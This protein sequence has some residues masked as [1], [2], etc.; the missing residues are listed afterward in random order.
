MSAAASLL[1]LDRRALLPVLSTPPS[2]RFL[3]A[4]IRGRRL[5]QPVHEAIG[6]DADGTGRSGVAIVF[7]ANGHEAQGQQRVLA[8]LD[9]G[10]HESPKDVAKHVQ[11]LLRL[12]TPCGTVAG[13][14]DGE[15]Q[16]ERR[17]FVHVGVLSDSGVAA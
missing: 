10:V 8:T 2:D 13:S 15:M 3:Q 5:G 6:H 9:F 14:V 17:Y 11:E 4:F 16:R 1:R 12:L 7:G